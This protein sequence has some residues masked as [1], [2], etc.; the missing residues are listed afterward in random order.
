MLK[1][2]VSVQLGSTLKKLPYH[3]AY[4]RDKKQLRIR[5]AIENFQLQLL[6]YFCNSLK[7]KENVAGLKEY[8]YSPVNA[9]VTFQT[10]S[11]Y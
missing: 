3:V 11:N 6:W 10:F 8:H 9:S 4:E 7:P 5:Y 2:I 1:L